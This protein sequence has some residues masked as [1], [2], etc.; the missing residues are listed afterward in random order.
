MSAE[1]AS[2]SRQQLL[3]SPLILN[4][5]RDSGTG[6][7]V[8]GEQIAQRGVAVLIKGGVQ[9]HVVA[10]E[11]QEFHD[12]LGFQGHLVGDLLE[13]GFTPQL[14]LQRPTCG[15]HLVQLFGDVHG[16]PDD[17]PLL[18]YPPRDRLTHPP[19]RVGGELE[20]LGVVE[21]LRPG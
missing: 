1:R 2:R 20:S 16:Q 5:Q 15:D 19:G 4:L 6:G 11:T 7:L 10:C 17:T 9:A 8:E 21:L 13:I 18:G 12:A 3:Q 14:A